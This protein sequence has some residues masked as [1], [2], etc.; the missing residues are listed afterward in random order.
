MSS[1]DQS[2]LSLECKFSFVMTISL[3]RKAF[4]GF[5]KHNIM[6]CSIVH[7][8]TGTYMFRDLCDR[9]QWF[10]A[11][12]CWW[13]ICC[14]NMINKIYASADKAL[15]FMCRIYTLDDW[16]TVLTM[17]DMRYCNCEVVSNHAQSDDNDGG[18][19]DDGS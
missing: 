16:A 4:C 10:W 5:C 18:C 15:R 11:R 7:A 13:C 14:V 19:F 8:L 1:V 17:L 9:C 2:A 12:E 6:M 3:M